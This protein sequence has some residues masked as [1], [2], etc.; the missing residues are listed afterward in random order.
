MPIRVRDV[1]AR[2][3]QR[4]R[5]VGKR[6]FV[7]GRRVD[8][9]LDALPVAVD[10]ASA[11]A[12]EV[13]L[14]IQAGGEHATEGFCTVVGPCPATRVVARHVGGRAAGDRVADEYQAAGG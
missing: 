13:A 8:D 9:R 10:A 4:V 11:V 1:A 7:E 3:P 14:R 6:A 5:I 12:D 2:V